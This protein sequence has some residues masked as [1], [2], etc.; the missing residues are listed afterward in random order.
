VLRKSIRNKE[1]PTY[2]ESRL[3]FALHHHGGNTGTVEF[4]DAGAAKTILVGAKVRLITWNSC[5][6]VM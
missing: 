4:I 3:L 1:Y 5:I 6:A 2:H